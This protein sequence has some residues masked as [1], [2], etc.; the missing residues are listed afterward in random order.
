MEIALAAMR[1]KNPF[2]HFKQT[3]AIWTEF[4]SF[5][6]PSFRKTPRKHQIYKLL[7]TNATLINLI[8]ISCNL[9]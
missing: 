9:R 4:I 7:H 6:F 3:G 8:I 5:F 1:A 2:Y